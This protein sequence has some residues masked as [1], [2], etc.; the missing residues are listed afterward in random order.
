MNVS[1]HPD[2]IWKQLSDED[3]WKMFGGKLWDRDLPDDIILYLTTFLTEV[4]VDQLR[5]V[6]KAFREILKPK[7]YKF[8]F[9]SLNHDIYKFINKIALR[10]KSPNFTVH[11]FRI[12]TSHKIGFDMFSGN[13]NQKYIEVNCFSGFIYDMK[14]NILGHVQQK[15]ALGIL[16]GRDFCRNIFDHEIEYFQ[17]KH[18]KLIQI[19][20]RFKTNQ[21]RGDFLCKVVFV[22]A[23]NRTSSQ[24]PYESNFLPFPHVLLLEKHEK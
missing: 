16:K 13:K 9:E 6:C 12:K 3:K 24:R 11:T 5:L 19:N 4:E 23:T 8:L 14:G 10:V 7:S 1:L 20:K 17:N 18:K 22:S 2:Q 21:N 15:N